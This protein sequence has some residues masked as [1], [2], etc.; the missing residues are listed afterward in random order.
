M[1][2]IMQENRFFKNRN[3]DFFKE[4][5]HTKIL[6]VPFLNFVHLLSVKIQSHRNHD[7]LFNSTA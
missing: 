3:A 2:Q 7:M 4:M 6:S 5:N 1:T